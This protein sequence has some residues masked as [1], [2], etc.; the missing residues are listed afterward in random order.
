MAGICLV[1]DS[2]SIRAD[3]SREKQEAP[4]RARRHGKLLTEMIAVN[5]K[6][7]INIVQMEM[8]FLQFR[9]ATMT[10]IPNKKG[11]RGSPSLLPSTA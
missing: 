1:F 5:C 2:R 8:Y 9:V 7:I 6:K 10:P 4:L 11:C 3:R